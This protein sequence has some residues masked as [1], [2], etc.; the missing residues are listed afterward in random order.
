MAHSSEDRALKAGCNYVQKTLVRI[1][2]R[3]L[4]GLG[5]QKNNSE[6]E[7][8]LMIITAYGLIVFHLVSWIGITKPAKTAKY[9]CDMLGFAYPA[10]PSRH[11]VPR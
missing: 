7:G 11:E 4:C 3:Q 9:I 5:S 1:Q 10:I 6:S 2:L 8:V